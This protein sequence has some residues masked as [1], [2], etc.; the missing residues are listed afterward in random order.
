MAVTADRRIAG[1]VSGGCVEGA[2]VE[3]AGEVLASGAPRLLKFGVADDTAWSVGLACGGAIEVFVEPLTEAIHAPRARTR[4]A[5]SGPSRSPPCSAGPGRRPEAGACSPT[6]RR[7]ETIDD[8]A[9]GA[10]RAAL[11]D[12]TQPTPAARRRRALRGRPAALAAAHRRRRRPHRGRPGPPGEGARLP[13]RPRGPA[14]VLRQRQALSER[15][16]D[17]LGLARRGARAAGVER[18]D[19]GRGAGP[20]PEARRPG[21][22]R[23]PGEPGLLRRRARQHAHPGEAAGAAAGRGRQRGRTWRSC[24]RRS[25]STSAAASPEEIALAVLA[26]IVAARNGR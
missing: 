14:R 12:G 18:G 21:A 24:T 1:S 9:L 6:A 10:A 15:R 16:R 26:Q 2:V 4:F 22:P 23:G 8:Q 17:R 25:A 13:D 11:A 3:A 7:R 20:R 5:R 19:R